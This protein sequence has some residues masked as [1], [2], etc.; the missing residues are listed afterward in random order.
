MRFAWASAVFLVVIAVVGAGPRTAYRAVEGELTDGRLA[1][2][3]WTDT[4]GPQMLVVDPETLVTAVV[5]GD[6]GEL[7]SPVPGGDTALSRLRGAVLLR[8]EG[9]Q[10]A[11]VRRWTP[12]RTGA[13]LT[14]DL[15]PSSH[16]LDRAVFEGLEGD[17][18]PL[19]V[20]LEVSGRWIETHPRDFAWLE[21][22]R[23]AGRLA[24]T[25]VNHTETHA[26]EPGRRL[27]ENFL[28][29]P[30][31]DLDAE[32][33]GVEQDLL[34]RGEVPS[35]FFRFPGLVSSAALVDRILAL[36][37]I[38]LGSS[39]WL[40]KQQSVRSGALVLTHAN[41]NEPEGLALLE[42]WDRA[43]HREIRAGEWHWLGLGDLAAGDAPPV[44]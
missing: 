31:T 38:P 23:D 9:L 10:N 19:P 29:L 2:R 15:C 4:Q 24:V 12:P 37:L 40:A 36:G 32:V 41:G 17:G 3:A 18:E 44:K 27:D 13:W 42:T 28:L 16:P 1:F 5:P 14:F 6:P 39:G 21:A 26:Y 11:G 43:E 7:K 8:R 34:D 20:M 30:G 25:W 33:F 35:V 22:E